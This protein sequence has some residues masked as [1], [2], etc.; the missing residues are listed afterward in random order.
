MVPKDQ[1]YTNLTVADTFVARKS[2]VTPLVIADRLQIDHDIILSANATITTQNNANANVV[3]TT[4]NQTIGGVKTFTDSVTLS[5]TSN[6]LV[7]GDGNTIT[8]TAPTPAA[9]LVYSL[10]DVGSA[11]SF[12]MTEGAQTIN[13]ATTFGTSILLPTTGGIPTP[14]TFYQRITETITFTSPSF[15]APRTTSCHFVRI[16][17]TVTMS[18]KAFVGVG[19]GVAG[20]IT[21]SAIPTQ[22]W[23]VEDVRI[24]MDVF[25]GGEPE[26]A[27]FFRLTT[28][29]TSEISRGVVIT[30]LGTDLLASRPFVGTALGLLGCQGFTTSWVV[31]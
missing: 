1:A 3:F 29:G 7:L 14:L 10:P 6:Q 11:A 25:E 28:A 2:I 4:G 20:T 27:G 17:D 31:A 16:G 18:M 19:N 23:P 9:S 24:P 13:G 12:V 8:L 26:L 21:G 5:G 15:A 22:F 30:V